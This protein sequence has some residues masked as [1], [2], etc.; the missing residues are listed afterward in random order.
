MRRGTVGTVG[1]AVHAAPV[2]TVHRIVTTTGA[3]VIAGTSMTSMPT[4]MQTEY[5]QDMQ[6][7]D[8]DSADPDNTGLVLSP[9]SRL[10]KR[11][12]KAPS[13]PDDSPPSAATAH[14]TAWIRLAQSV[15][16]K[17]SRFRG[18]KEKGELNASV[19][20]LQPVDPSE[21]LDYLDVV[22]NPMDF[23]TIK[24]KLECCMYSDWEEFHDDMM[25]V[26]DN[27]LLYNQ[28][29][30]VVR[31]DCEDV[32]QY[33]LVEYEKALERWRKFQVSQS[34]SKKQIKFQHPS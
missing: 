10:S 15:L 19:W 23:G 12:R 26:R 14:L 27:C 7:D 33:Y 5:A 2:R 9:D 32:F 30:S 3:G 13:A 24:R 16:A 25:L 8:S 1:G 6:A 29:G 20:F 34:P 11:K 4:S 28:D 17:V 21:V 31:R 18:N 22:E